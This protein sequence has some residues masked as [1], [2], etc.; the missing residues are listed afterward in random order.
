MENYER[1]GGTLKLPV[2]MGLEATM[3]NNIVLPLRQFG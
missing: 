1:E 2:L 3:L